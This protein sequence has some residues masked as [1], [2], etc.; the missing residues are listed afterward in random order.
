[1]VGGSGTRTSAR[2][3]EVIRSTHLGFFAVALDGWRGTYFDYSIV[4]LC[5]GDVSAQVF[6]AFVTFRVDDLRRL[7]LAGLLAFRVL[8]SGSQ[9]QGV[10][11]A[12]LW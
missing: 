4:E 10:L 12:L 9:W 8:L 2:A 1:M 5:D 6:E 11:H 3:S 7:R